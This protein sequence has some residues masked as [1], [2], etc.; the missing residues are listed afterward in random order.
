MKAGYIYILTNFH[1]S[2]F[3]IGVTSNLEK[4]IYEHKNELLDG[5][6]KKYRLKKLVYFEEYSQIEEAIVREKQLKNWH[7]DWKINLV[8]K[9]NPDLKD[10]SE[11][12]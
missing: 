1:N 6:T 8:K 9:T 12:I 4:R 2:T 7:R 3:Y 5:F 10:L 11:G